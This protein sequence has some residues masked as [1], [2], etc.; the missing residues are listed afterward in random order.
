[1]Q[2][3]AVLGQ[4]AKFWRLYQ[5]NPTQVITSLKSLCCRFDTSPL[6]QL[7]TAGV[8]TYLRWDMTQILR[9]GNNPLKPSLWKAGRW[10][11]ASTQAGLHPLFPKL[12]CC[13]LL[14]ALFSSLPSFTLSSQA[15]HQDHKA[16]APHLRFLLKLHSTSQVFCFRSCAQEELQ[17]SFSLP[18]LFFIK[19]ILS[20][21]LI[22]PFFSLW[23]W[24][25]LLVCCKGTQESEPLLVN[26]LNLDLNPWSSAEV[27]QFKKK[28]L[29]IFKLKFALHRQSLQATQL[30][31]I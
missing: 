30:W 8:H 4:E 19:S 17:L 12:P 16:R 10:S 25:F 21:I 24:S 9:N 26:S 31:L 2:L 13:W 14:N 27:L 6:E 15:D 5:K 3:P 28:I 11:H 20:L 7:L 18:R 23:I 22:Y 1:M 29:L